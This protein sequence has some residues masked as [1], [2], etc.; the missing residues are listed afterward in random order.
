MAVL[1]DATYNDICD[2]HEMC[3]RLKITL[4]ILHSNVSVAFEA[5]K[6]Q[7]QLFCS[8]IE[9]G[10]VEQCVLSTHRSIKPDVYI[11]LT[12]AGRCFAHNSFAGMYD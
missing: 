9:F 12:E 4:S 1:K 5:D 2:V 3:E 11:A 7:N 6:K 10:F 8:L